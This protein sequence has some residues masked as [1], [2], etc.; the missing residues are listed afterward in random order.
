MVTL[1]GLHTMRNKCKQILSSSPISLKAFFLQQTQL[2]KAIKR[3]PRLDAQ[4]IC[5][6]RLLCRECCVSRVSPL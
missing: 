3:V 4:S 6:S 5:L 1:I 2:V